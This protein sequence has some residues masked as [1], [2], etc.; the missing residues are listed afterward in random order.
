MNATIDT[1]TIAGPVLGTVGMPGFALAT[2]LV[3]LA[4]LRGSDRV[5]LDR[6][7]AGGLGIA[8]G[9]FS[10]AAGSVWATFAHGV[11]QGPVSVLQ[12]GTFGNVGVGATAIAIMATTFLFRWKKLIVPAALGIAGGVVAG[13]A[14]GIWGFFHGLALKGAELL[15]SL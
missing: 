4:G 11:A 7:K 14:G 13:Q 1:V 2:G 6:D 5:R 8:L 9:T 3:L 10:V 15:G 12:G